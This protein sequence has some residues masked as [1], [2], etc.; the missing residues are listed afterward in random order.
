MNHTFKQR[1]ALVREAERAIIREKRAGHAK[2]FFVS[3]FVIV[4]YLIVSF[5]QQVMA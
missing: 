5:I 2:A 3:L 1:S 4:A